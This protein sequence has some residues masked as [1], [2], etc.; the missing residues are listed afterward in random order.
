MRKRLLFWCFLC[1][2]VA[3]L[4]GILVIPTDA[5]RAAL[6]A[7]RQQWLTDSARYAGDLERWLR[8][9]ILIDSIAQ[10]I[11]TDSLKHLYHAAMIASDPV[12]I[13]RAIWCERA[14]LQARYGYTPSIW[15]IQA[16]E[17]VSWTRAEQSAA[18]SRLPPRMVFDEDAC[19]D[20]VRRG[21]TRVG[22]TSLF[23]QPPTRPTLPPKP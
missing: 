6:Q 20:T 9:S 7:A 15:A 3:A 16:A 21:I 17:S 5:D 14:R 2:G 13:F 10:A 8:D 12:P 23:L 18:E 11:P 22:Q 4:V 1:L 19:G